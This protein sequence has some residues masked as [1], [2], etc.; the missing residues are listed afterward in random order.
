M[1]LGGRHDASPPVKAACAC[2]PAYA[3]LRHHCTCD[4]MSDNDRTQMMRVITQVPQTPVGSGRLVVIAGDELGRSF[5]LE[6]GEARI[7]RTPDNDICVPE[8]D[9]SRL[10]AVLFAEDGVVHLRDNASTNGTYVNSVRIHEAVLADGDLI[11]VGSWTFKFLFKHSEETAYH[12]ELY[13]LSTL[14]GLTQLCNKRHFREVLERELARSRRLGQALSLMLF[15]VDHFKRC[16]DTYGHLAGDQV[17]RELAALVR[18]AVRR[19]DVVARVGGEEFAV[20]MP[21]TALDGGATL[22]DAVREKVAQAS[23]VHEG[24]T[25]PVTISIGVVEAGEVSDGD[26]DGLLAKA[27]ARLYAAKHAGRNRVVAAG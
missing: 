16:N 13:R 11:R 20:L 6:H 24:V 26:V 14:D 23:I 7:G 17:L 21:T 22:A 18:G 15:D 4:T 3:F 19:H 12:E 1:A 5:A 25:I 27:D 9:V 10:H 8:V 2:G